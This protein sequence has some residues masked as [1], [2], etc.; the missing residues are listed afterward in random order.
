[1]RFIPTRVHGVIDYAVGLLVLASP[2][3]FGFADSATGPWLHVLL[4]AVILASAA[5]TDFELGMVRVIPMPV[6]LMLD[7]GIGAV[8]LVSPWLFGVQ[9]YV[10][11]HIVAGIFEIG[12]AL[13]TSTRPA[14]SA[15]AA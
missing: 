10:G 3:L 11:L 6:H 15:V 2:W 4:G 7:A 9:A 1:M 14:D 5:M 13:M 12:T 8:A